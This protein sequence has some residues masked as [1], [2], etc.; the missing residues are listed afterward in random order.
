MASEI[1]NTTK[2]T[3]RR[4]A[5]QYIFG[6]NQQNYVRTA[7]LIINRVRYLHCSHDDVVGC[8]AAYAADGVTSDARTLQQPVGPRGRTSY[9]TDDRLTVKVTAQKPRLTRPSSLVPRTRVN[10]I[11]SVLAVYWRY[12]ARA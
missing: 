9:V 1:W 3:E 10:D 11:Y 7:D 2:T 8:V 12:Y 6:L 5:I 4:I